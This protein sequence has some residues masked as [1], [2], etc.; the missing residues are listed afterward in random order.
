MSGHDDS[1][2]IE[3][4]KAIAAPQRLTWWPTSLMLASMAGGLIVARDNAALMDG[5]DIDQNAIV[6]EINGIPNSGSGW[7][8]R[9]PMKVNAKRNREIE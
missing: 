4:T 3:E 2:T 8:P 1:L 5:S 9:P 7:W 6:A